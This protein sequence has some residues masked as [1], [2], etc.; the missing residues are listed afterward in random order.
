[1]SSVHGGYD[2]S[3][4]QVVSGFTDG[5]G[6]AAERM[7]KF[8]D[9]IPLQENETVTNDDKNAVPV[10]E[11]IPIDIGRRVRATPK[12][13][14]QV[15]GGIP[16]K[17]LEAQ[18]IE[19]DKEDH[20]ALDESAEFLADVFGVEFSIA[21][22]KI[23]VQSRW[24]A[25]AWVLGITGLVYLKHRGSKLFAFLKQQLDETSDTKNVE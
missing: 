7:N 1:M 22:S 21:E 4:L 2:E 8:A 18:G 13:L 9:T 19:L 6:N 17:L 3:E 25:L 10:S 5:E 24:W 11:P 15:L 12:K 16:A 20:A 14:K 23:Q